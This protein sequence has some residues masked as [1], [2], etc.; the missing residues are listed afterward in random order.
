MSFATWITKKSITTSRK[1]AR[2]TKEQAI[3]V[4]EEAIKSYNAD[5]PKK[6]LKKYPS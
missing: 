2:Y 3:L 5:L 4:K 1:I 6:P